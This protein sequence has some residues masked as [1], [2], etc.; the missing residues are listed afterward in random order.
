MVGEMG[1]FLNQP[2]TAT[3]V[4][5][6]SSVLYRLS[7]EAYERMKHMDPE[8]ALHLYQWIGRVLATRLTENNSTLQVLLN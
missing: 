3:V 8:L 1:L 5:S 4:V 2:R 6:E 7:V